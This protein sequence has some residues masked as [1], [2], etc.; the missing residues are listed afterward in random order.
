MAV[1]DYQSLMRPLLRRAEAGDETYISALVDEIANELHLS[2]ADAA[3]LVPS[4]RQTVLSNRLHW[5]KT[6]M[7]RAALLQSTRH[8]YFRITDRGRQALSEGPERIDNAYLSRF[9]EFVDWKNKERTASEASPESVDE[10]KA[11][12]ED[13]IAANF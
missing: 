6:Y 9:Q 5:A 3:Q 12:P 13:Q 1:P 2:E 10:T 7:Q 4:G 8:G 11:S